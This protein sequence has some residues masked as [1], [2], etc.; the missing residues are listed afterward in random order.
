MTSSPSTSASTTPSSIKPPLAVP[1]TK[2]SAGVRTMA[3]GW[4][5][6]EDFQATPGP[7]II[8]P[9]TSVPS[10]VRKLLVKK[11]KNDEVESSLPTNAM[12]AVSSGSGGSSRLPQS[13]GVKVEGGG[14]ERGVRGTPVVV[15]KKMSPSKDLPVK[16]Q[17]HSASEDKSVLDN[18]MLCKQLVEVL[19]SSCAFLDRS[20]SSTSHYQLCWL[21]E[22]HPMAERADSQTQET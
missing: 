16:T 5:S 7:S 15:H 2:D 6:D 4:S 8:S 14:E 11:E 13:S 12:S 10:T 1:A 17:A 20:C 22:G 18:G 21:R 19:I 9:T 3:V